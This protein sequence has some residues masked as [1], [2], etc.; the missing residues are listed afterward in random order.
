MNRVQTIREAL[1]GL[2]SPKQAGPIAPLLEQL[3]DA[4][5]EADDEAL[6]S[7]LEVIA[8]RE[9]NHLLAT[10]KNQLSEALQQ[11]AE[12][13]RGAGP[14]PEPPPIPKDLAGADALQNLVD[15]VGNG[16]GAELHD[17]VMSELPS[18][19][20]AIQRA[21]DTG[22]TKA[23][24]RTARSLEH[25]SEDAAT[26]LQQ[27]AEGLHAALELLAEDRSTDAAVQFADALRQELAATLTGQTVAT[28]VWTSAFDSA[29]RANDLAI[30]NA[31]A[32]R[33]WA[34]AI[35]D[36]D[37]HGVRDVADMLAALA[38]DQDNLV[39]EAEAR[40]C[41]AFASIALGDLIEANL[42]V[43]SLVDRVTPEHPTGASVWLAAAQ[44]AQGL[45]E[46][47]RAEALYAAVHSEGHSLE[48]RARAALGLGAVANR[49]LASM[50]EECLA[51]AE[52][53]VLTRVGVAYSDELAQQD[54]ISECARTVL[55][56]ARRLEEQRFRPGL[57]ALRDQVIAVSQIV[58]DERFA[59]ALDHHTFKGP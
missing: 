2:P 18:A 14:L 26:T 50:F 4:A 6:G 44:I 8:S 36:R 16:Q 59:S 32:E 33:L 45:D 29:I 24:Q 25:L 39:I 47:E 28:R 42:L 48:L 27:T 37:M 20:H 54:N 12:R 11:V 55:R 15:H 35:D 5:N 19:I 56:A 22:D 38:R 51:G 41:G 30:A 49:S 57:I 1:R 52:P 31:C 43:H 58:G 34:E 46:F 40:V 3:Q 13:V 53:P 7:L 17:Q 10:L 21:L 23:L 9:G